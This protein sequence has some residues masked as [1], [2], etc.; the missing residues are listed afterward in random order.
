MGYIYV[1][2]VR[3]MRPFVCSSWKVNCWRIEKQTTTIQIYSQ[4]QNMSY[5]DMKF[6][7]LVVNRERLKGQIYMFGYVTLFSFTNKR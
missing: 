3:Q 1:I 5:Q 4:I 7:L 6:N 2:L